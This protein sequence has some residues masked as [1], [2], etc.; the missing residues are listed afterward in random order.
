M[1]NGL[2]VTAWR[3]SALFPNELEF[4][5]WEFGSVFQNARNKVIFSIAVFTDLCNK[6]LDS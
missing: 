2:Q 6:T 5:Y 4:I 3:R 1:C